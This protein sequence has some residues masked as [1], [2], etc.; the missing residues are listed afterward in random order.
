MLLVTSLYSYSRLIFN[1]NS[2][3]LFFI[4][5]LRKKIKKSVYDKDNLNC[6]ESEVDDAN[7]SSMETEPKVKL[8]P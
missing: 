3:V 2:N 8:N 1:L 7:L 6:K 5:F 4:F